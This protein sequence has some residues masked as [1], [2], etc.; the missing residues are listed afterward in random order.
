MNIYINQFNTAT[1]QNLLPLS[2]GLLAAYARNQSE[3]RE[4]CRIRICAERDDPVT[5][6]AAYDDPAILGF[7][8]YSW[9]FR[10]SME[11]AR[12]AKLHHPACHIVLGGPEIPRSPVD[13]PRFFFEWPFIDSI[14]IGEGEL[15][16]GELTLALLLGKDL[17]LVAGLAF[18][19]ADRSAVLNEPRPRIASFAGMPSPF[20]DGTFDEFLAQERQPVT[21]ALVE[22]NRG[23]PFS[24]TFCDWGQSTKSKVRDIELA[25]VEEEIEWIARHRLHM[26]W[27]TDANFGLRP[28]DLQIAEIIASARRRHGCPQ[29]LSVSWAKNCPGRVREIYEILREAGVSCQVTLTLQSL[30]P[31]TLSAIR[32]SNI[33]LE[34]FNA[35]KDD[36]GRRG[37]P[38]YTEFIFPLPEETYESFID[39]LIRSLTRNR[40]DFFAAYVCRLIPNTELASSAQRHQYALQTR[41]CEIKIA[42]RVTRPDAV[43]EF[44][45]LVVATSS[46]S[47]AEWAKTFQVTFLLSALYNHRLA[48]LALNVLQDYYSVE[49]R[50]FLEFVFEC[51]HDLGPILGRMRA[52]LRDHI[53]SILASRTPMLQVPEYGDYYWEANESTYLIACLDLPAFFADLQRVTIA[54]LKASGKPLGNPATLGEL[55][56]FQEEMIPNC[57]R[58]YPYQKAFHHDWLELAA[59]GSGV[60]ANESTAQFIYLFD[61]YD[62][63]Q[64]LALNDQCLPCQSPSSALATQRDFAM[65]QIKVTSVGQNAVCKVERVP[66]H[67]SRL[68]DNPNDCCREV[69]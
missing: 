15:T 36:F 68:A 10:Y 4:R 69:A 67:R 24:C 40:R 8:C 29:A 31:S 47:E 56:A 30:N 62:R 7:S 53:D 64:V 49:I 32:R 35:L 3:I 43:A 2:A 33:K 9:N 28:Q 18:A 41:R 20:L 50:P 65:A 11:V 17:S 21:G 39:G 54:F 52:N 19:G 42:R 57:H 26:V 63:H 38:T 1:D 37:I 14:A 46:M 44:E 51:R 48:D 22:T 61:L 25:R 13:I 45:E 16:F 66:F 34:A 60:L 27:A 58:S 23:C 59:R 12:L 6:A 55:F 5:R